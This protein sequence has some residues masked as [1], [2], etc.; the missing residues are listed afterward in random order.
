M[1]KKFIKLSYSFNFCI[2][3]ISNFC[4]DFLQTLY[5]GYDKEN[6]TLEKRFESWYLNIAKPILEEII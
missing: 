6:R 1:I 3:K 2:R 4:F 5:L